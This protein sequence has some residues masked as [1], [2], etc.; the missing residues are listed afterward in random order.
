L[1]ELKDNYSQNFSLQVRKKPDNVTLTSN[2]I[3]KTGEGTN[4][5]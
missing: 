1:E 2:P 4:V 5:G 3:F